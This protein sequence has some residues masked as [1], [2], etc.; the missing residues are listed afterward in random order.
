MM[1]RTMAWRM[2]GR[3]GVVV[4]EGGQGSVGAAR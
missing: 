2:E 4:H 3:L 1:A